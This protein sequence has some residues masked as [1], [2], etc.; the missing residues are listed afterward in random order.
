MSELIRLLLCAQLGFGLELPVS[1]AFVYISPLLLQAGLNGIQSSFVLCAGSIIGL[2]AA[3]ILGLISDNV[4]SP[5]G[6]RR[7]FVLVLSACVAF[8]LFILPQVRKNPFLLCV[9][10][11]IL[12][13]SSQVCLS[14]CEALLADLFQSP[15]GVYSLMLNFGSTL[16]YLFAVVDWS[17]SKL[18][19]DS[20]S[21]ILESSP[22]IPFIT[23]DNRTETSPAD[24]NIRVMFLAIGIIFSLSFITALWA[25]REKT[26]KSY[27]CIIPINRVFS[28]N[29][30]LHVKSRFCAV[31]RR[32]VLADS[33]SWASILCFK[34]FFS[35]FI[36]Q[37]VYK[38]H[39]YPE[40]V[41][42]ETSVQKQLLLNYDNGVRAASLA[43]FF[44][45]LVAT[46]FSSIIER[47][48]KKV[49]Y[50][51]VYL[52]GVLS[53]GISLIPIALFRVYSYGAICFL[54]AI[55]GFGCTCAT[56]MPFIILTQYHDN[57]ELYFWDASDGKS[58]G[59]GAD[60]GLLDASYFACQVIL[61]SFVGFLYRSSLRAPLVA[62]I[63]LAFCAA[64]AVYTIIDE[65][66]DV[67]VKRQVHRAGGQH[68]LAVLIDQTS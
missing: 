54:C 51:H 19:K 1:V 39:P 21:T 47:T 30:L 68:S 18:Y 66:A 37:V 29:P 45:S 44:Q 60:I 63:V 61:F 6:R 59:I 64:V 55:S 36:A 46:I 8:S 26:T 23:F 50:R 11:I 2:I 16:G 35:D 62:A 20:N 52:F 22:D 28:T 34:F 48:A 38:G 57:K 15:Y 41:S 65:K 31:I 7:P 4:S 43:L 17:Q 33:I 56:A 27:Q 3:P 53:F 32:L 67:I 58:R 13:S 10:V 24:T 12:D 25:G 14:A 5:F 49:G 40:N 42:N 9:V